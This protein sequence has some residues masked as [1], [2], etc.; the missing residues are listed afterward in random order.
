MSPEYPHISKQL[1]N[2]RHLSRLA[3]LYPSFTPSQLT[4]LDKRSDALK[5]S[6]NPLIIIKSVCG[7][8]NGTYSVYINKFC[9]GEYCGKDFDLG[10]QVISDT[11]LQLKIK[12]NG[13]SVGKC[14]VGCEYV[15]QVCNIQIKNKFG[16]KCG[17]LLV[18]VI[19]SH[20][21][22]TI[23]GVPSDPLNTL[24]SFIQT[25]IQNVIDDV[26]IEI[27][28]TCSSA[29]SVDYSQILFDTMS[30]GLLNGELSFSE[31]RRYVGQFYKG[32]T[33]ILNWMVQWCTVNSFLGQSKENV[34]FVIGIVENDSKQV[35]EV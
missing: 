23:K 1:T 30:S 8:K 12:L 35:Y 18:S 9:I 6:N 25:C 15:D 16:F 20:Q 29:W 28:Q 21:S 10:Y 2:P 34:D 7:L 3:Q 5:G 13:K 32:Q 27:V 14:M 26:C 33:P 4:P 17:L 19:T 31:W 24:E 22:Y 11:S